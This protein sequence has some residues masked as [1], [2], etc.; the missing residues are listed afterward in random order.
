MDGIGSFFE[1]FIASLPPGIEAIVIS[2][3]PDRALNYAEL[4]DLVRSKLPVGRPY[5]LL[6]ESFSGPIAI[7][8]AA[9]NPEGLRGLVLVCSFA[10]YPIPVPGA[11]RSLISRLPVS[12][13]PISIVAQVLLGRHATPTLRAQLAT[14]IAKVNPVVWR[15]RLRA[16]L[17]ADVTAL[18][19]NI[20]IP[21]LY[22]R[23]ANDR[24]VPPRSSELI[25]RLLAHTKIVEIEAPH[26]LLQ[27]KPVESAARIAAFAHEVNDAV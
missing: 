27:A 1:D 12:L 6:G 10:R 9:S 24:V 11:I 18:L 8:I 16:A 2:Y 7:S 26:F 4:E 20:E 5:L 23:A 13:V 17:S 14:A 15:T 21:V 19:R 25:S 22:L 3:P